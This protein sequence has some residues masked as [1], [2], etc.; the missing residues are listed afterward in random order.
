MKT[1]CYFTRDVAK[2]IGKDGIKHVKSGRARRVRRDAEPAEAAGR[3]PK[4]EN[5]DV[6]DIEREPTTMAD[7][8]V[9]DVRDAEII[10]VR[11][12]DAHDTGLEEADVNATGLGTAAVRGI[13]AGKVA[14]ERQPSTEAS[15]MDTTTNSSAGDP[16]QYADRVQ[17]AESV[18][19][20]EEDR[21]RRVEE[22]R[23]ILEHHRQAQV[24]SD[25]QLGP[26]QDVVTRYAQIA[27]G[28]G[29]LLPTGLDLFG[30]A[31][32]HLAMASKLAK[33]FNVP[34]SEHRGKALIAAVTGSATSGMFAAPAASLVRMLP[35]VGNVAGVVGMGGTAFA[36]TY[37]LG[38]VLTAHF[39][40]GGNLLDFDQVKA[41]Q[42]FSDAMSHGGQFATE[43]AARK[44]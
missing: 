23:R 41:K 16:G 33:V 4:P 42:M 9:T 32:V 39:A 40:S 22:A 3:E 38:K 43:A 31:A 19:R 24:A 25:P 27:A 17:Q 29:G 7:R 34:F 21:K 11:S 13:P 15:P 12:A 5:A 44:T 28:V 35:I 18:L 1:L 14:V 8:H 37:A 26:A 10:D 36:S 2:K 30:V 20:E 6:P